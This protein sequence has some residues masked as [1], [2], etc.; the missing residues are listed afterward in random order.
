MSL[1]RKVRKDMVLENSKA[2]EGEKAKEVNKLLEEYQDIT[3]RL[4]DLD[5]SKKKVLARLYELSII[6]VNETTKYSYKVLEQAGRQSIS[7]KA[8]KETEPEI[9]N[10]LESKGLVTQGES[11]KKIS[12]IKLKG[13][14]SSG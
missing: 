1:Y 2:I 8:L 9:F 6:G 5:A 10:T 4:S 3:T 11:F 14:R 13:S 7:V 12:S